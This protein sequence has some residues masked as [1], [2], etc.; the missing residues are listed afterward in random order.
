MESINE[1][2]LVLIPKSK[3]PKQVVDLRSISLCNVCYK[4]I[5]KVLVNRMKRILH[6]IISPNQS[7]FIPKR[8]ITDNAIL[9]YECIRWLRNK[10]SGKIAW[11]CLKLDISKAYDQVEWYFLRGVMIQMGF[12]A[13]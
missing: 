7:V 1:T 6:L 8:Y 4:I 5:S 13:D 10:H 2:M 3:N 9:G 11:A 12:G